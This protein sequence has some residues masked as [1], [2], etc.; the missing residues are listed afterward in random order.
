MA[1]APA[2]DPSGHHRR[3]A[4]HDVLPAVPARPGLPRA[5]LAVGDHAPGRGPDRAAP[6]SAPGGRSWPTTTAPNRPTSPS[7][8]TELRA[9]A[10]RRASTSS[11]PRTASRRSWCSAPCGPPGT[12]SSRTRPG[13]STTATATSSR[14]CA[15]DEGI[16]YLRREG[17]EHAKAGNVNA[18]LARTVR[19]VRGHLRRR[20][21]TGTELPAPGAAAL[22]GPGRGVRPV[23]AV[24][25]STPSTSSPP[26]QP[27]RSGS[28][29]SSSAPA[30]TTSTRRSAS[31]RT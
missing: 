26:A 21:R 11:S 28:S 25:T 16:G 13:Y 22:R 12:W 27:R 7:A 23:A 31:A 15:R 30:R 3:A 9:G 1:T 8:A 24:T 2:V 20:P 17:R 19:R 10:P 29:T 6:R 14:G 18:A 5:A 4:R